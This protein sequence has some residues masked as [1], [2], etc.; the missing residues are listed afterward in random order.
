[1]RTGTRNAMVGLALL[2]AVPVAA[3]ADD[4]DAPSLPSKAD[5]PAAEPDHDQLLEQQMLEL[6]ERLA[7][8]EDAQH[9][10]KSPLS[11]HGYADLGFFAPNG[12]GGVGWVR[13]AGHVQMPQYSDYAWTFLG[14]ILSTTVNSRGEV[15]S[16][17]DAPGVTRFDSIDSKGAPGFLVNEINLR[18]GYELTDQAIVRTSVDFM[19]RTGHEFSIGDFMEVDVAELEYVL[20]RDGNTSIFVG[21]SLPTFGIE[22]KE[23]KSDQR[24]GI[25]P[26]L[27]ERYTGGS[28][29][30]LKFRSKLLNEWV[31]LAG[32]IT[33]GSSVTEQF[34]FSREVDSNAGKTLSG[35]A[36]LSAPVGDLG[37]W[38]AGDRLELGLSGE[39]GPQDNATDSGGDIKFVGVDVQYLGTSFWLKAQAMRGDAPGRDV[40]DAFGLRLHKSGYVEL[41]WLMLARL[42]ILLRAE[43]RDA[44]VTLGHQRA[45]ITKSA[46]LTGGLRMVLSSNVVLKAEYLNNREYGGIRPF[47]NDVFTSS[48]VLAY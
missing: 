17:G 10:A 47:K 16:L 34:H 27:V 44:V 11:I 33:N 3:W 12:N 6:K 19:P 1:M 45:Y 9:K 48:L 46:R 31:I 36:A 5:E 35:R 42:G 40:D 30:G 13:D 28:Q 14:D 21:K 8:S 37:R 32:S 39:W 24:F 4:G 7:R 25:T 22:Y 18:L 29:L 26:S 20:T 43:A 38:I 15:A 23:R 2:V 41:D